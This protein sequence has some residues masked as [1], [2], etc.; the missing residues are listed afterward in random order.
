M[1]TN[2]EAQKNYNNA[3]KALNQI[4]R[5]DTATEEERRQTTRQRDAL[6]LNY[7]GRQIDDVHARSAAYAKFIEAMATLIV[8]LG[9][10]RPLQGLQT[11]RGIVN[12]AAALIGTAQPQ[13]G[14]QKP[15][16]GE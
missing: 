12:Q 9:P 14:N 5:S 1:I 8:E 3:R 2:D 11:L 15:G 7:I 16:P 10:D 13:E 4:I 6:I